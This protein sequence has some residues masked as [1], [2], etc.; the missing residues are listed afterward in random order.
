[1]GATS[2]VGVCCCYLLQGAKRKVLNDYVYGHPLRRSQ[3][4]TRHAARCVRHMARSKHPVCT[5]FPAWAEAGNS[6]GMAI[7]A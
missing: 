7:S 3:G 4:W 2:C 1:M 6:K 5:T